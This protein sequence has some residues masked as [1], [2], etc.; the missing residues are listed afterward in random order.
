M[1]QPVALIG[2]PRLTTLYAA[3]LHQAGR[4]SREIDGQAAFLAGIRK[5]AEELR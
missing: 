5:L 1:D 3:A 4:E 2:S